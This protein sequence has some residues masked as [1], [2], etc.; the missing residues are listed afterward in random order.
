LADEHETQ[1]VKIGDDGEFS[2][3]LAVPETKTPTFS[4]Q[5]NN[6]LPTYAFDWFSVVWLMMFVILSGL[7]V[8]SLCFAA[9]A[10]LI[11]GVYMPWDKQRNLNA[12]DEALKQCDVTLRVDERYYSDNLYRYG[13]SESW[14]SGPGEDGKWTCD[15][16]VVPTPESVGHV[17]GD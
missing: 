6:S 3:D 10:I 17:S 5:R 12:I 7:I 16:E 13:R 8:V 4:W 15:C 11:Y 14:C 9:S 2:F 1:D